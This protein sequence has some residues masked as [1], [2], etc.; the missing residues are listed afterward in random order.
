MSEV[1]RDRLKIAKQRLNQQ[2][3]LAI[4]HEQDEQEERQLAFR[5]GEQMV[6]WYR[7]ERAAGRL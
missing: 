6:Q 4:L 2:I 7:R 1:V 3:F 5:R